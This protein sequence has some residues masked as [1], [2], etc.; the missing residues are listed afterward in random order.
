[1]FNRSIK[2]QFP[3]ASTIKPFVALYA[4]ENKL[5]QPENP[6][7]TLV[8]SKLMPNLENLKTGTPMDTAK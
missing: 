3:L 7:K 2:G 1:M 6:Y 8:I 5:I 4:L